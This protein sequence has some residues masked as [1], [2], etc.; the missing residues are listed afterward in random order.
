MQCVDLYRGRKSMFHIPEI[1]FCDLY[2]GEYCS[3][4][5]KCSV[6]II[7][8]LCFDFKCCHVIVGNHCLCCI[9]FG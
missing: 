4:A 6:K 5:I 3:R 7:I 2:T 1:N 8:S 9:L